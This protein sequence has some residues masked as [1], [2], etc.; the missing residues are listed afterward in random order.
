MKLTCR[1]SILLAVALFAFFTGCGRKKTEI[2]T[3]QRKEAELLVNEAEFA[4]NLRDWAR[5]EGLLTKAVQLVPD[6]GVYWTS[7]GSMRV[8]TGN[9]A[10]AKQAYE[11]ALKSYQADVAADKTKANVEPWLKQVYVLALLGRTEQ[12]RTLLADIAK[13]FPDHRN[14]RAFVDGKQFDR[15]IADPLF[16]DAA[17]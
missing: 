2:T 12:A 1:E 3:Q 14:V 4:M 5:A 9:R 11:E 6:E 13:R 15:M 7:L 16:K 8:R 17:L 10:G